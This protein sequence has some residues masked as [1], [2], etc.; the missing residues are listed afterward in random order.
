MGNDGFLIVTSHFLL[1]LQFR[2]L[3]LLQLLHD[4][5]DVR[6]ADAVEVVA[7]GDVVVRDVVVDVVVDVV[8]G[9]VRV[10]R[11]VGVVDRGIVDVRGR[12]GGR[13][14]RAFDI[15]CMIVFRLT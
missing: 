1:D 3:L 8:R 2:F 15:V 10:I 5:L 13:W 12:R 9:V 14:W 11:V 7:D 4:P 6:L